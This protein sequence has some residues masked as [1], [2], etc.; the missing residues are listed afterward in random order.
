MKKLKLDS[1]FFFFLIVFIYLIYFTVE[2]TIKQDITWHPGF[3]VDTDGLIYLWGTFLHIW[4][5]PNNSL[6]DVATAKMLLKSIQSYKLKLCST[7]HL[8][9]RGYNWTLLAHRS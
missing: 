1:H 2:P 7:S 3:S 9:L 8:T 6:V 4:V 5:E